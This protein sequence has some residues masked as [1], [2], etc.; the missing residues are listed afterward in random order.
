[1]FKHHANGMVFL[2]TKY[3]KTFLWRFGFENCKNTSI[4]MESSSC[5]S[6]HDEDPCDAILYNRLL[7]ASLVCAILAL[8]FNMKFHK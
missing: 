4:P 2:Q 3:T 5:L 7:D 6:P 8:T 1:M